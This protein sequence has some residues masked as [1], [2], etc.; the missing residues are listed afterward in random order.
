MFDLLPDELKFEICEYLS[1]LD[2]LKLSR[3]CK[4][5][6][7][8]LLDR[9]YWIQRIQRFHRLFEPIISNP[10]AFIFDLTLFQ[11]YVI[12]VRNCEYD[13]V[14]SR[15]M[16][17]F[18]YLFIEHSLPKFD[19]KLF[20]KYL[21]TWNEFNF[22]ENFSWSLVNGNVPCFGQMIP[23]DWNSIPDEIPYD[24]QLNIRGLFNNI[25]ER[26]YLQLLQWM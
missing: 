8:L 11:S 16:K 23:V 10:D 18:I 22:N 12:M 20:F 2:I 7:K 14:R 19:K 6:S 26:Y 21:E 4:C 3:T 25:D 1:G 13:L 9:F 17:Y 15:Q 24:Y 5:L